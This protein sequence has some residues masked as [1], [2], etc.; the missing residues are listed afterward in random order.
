MFFPI[1]SNNHF[2]TK[3]TNLINDASKKFRDLQTLPF[4]SICAGD[5]TLNCGNNGKCISLPNV[6]NQNQFLCVCDDGFTGPKCETAWDACL[7]SGPTSLCL[8]GGICTSTDTHPFYQCKCTVGFTGNNCELE[9]NVCK[10]NNPCQNGGKCTYI[11]E[12]LPIL[13][14]CLTGYTG[15][16]CQ[17]TV[18]H[19]I[20]GAGILLHPGQII[21][22]WAFLIFVLA[23]ILYCTF[24]VVYDI[25]VQIRAKKKQ[26]EKED[27]EEDVSS[28]TNK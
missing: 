20:G 8:N 5:Q 16:Y 14:T 6:S 10:T 11:G 24:S 19:G 1:E 12:N 13:C 23:T 28:P 27:V 15:D 18:E 26:K 2:T 3:N 25:I 4:E 17:I 9:N 21:M 7:S 22:M